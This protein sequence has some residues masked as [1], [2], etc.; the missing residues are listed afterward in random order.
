[1]S[2]RLWSMGSRSL[3]NSATL[4]VCG[5]LSLVCLAASAQAQERREREPNSVYAERRA[6]LATQVD[7]PIV[8][9]GF[10][11]REENSQTYIFEQEESFYYLTGH[12]EEGAGLLI[13]PAPKNVGPTNGP[14]EL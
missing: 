4:T 6:K 9:W 13:L 10:T 14:R 2:G 5:L 3:L 11:G 1:M 8:L 7:G 12:N